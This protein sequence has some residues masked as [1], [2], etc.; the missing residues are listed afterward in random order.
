FAMIGKES[1]LGLVQTFRMVEKIRFRNNVEFNFGEN[2]MVYEGSQ[3]LLV[4]LLQFSVPYVK[5]LEFSD[6]VD[7]WYDVVFDILSKESKQKRLLIHGLPVVKDSARTALTNMVD[8]GVLIEFKDIKII[9]LFQ[10]PPC[11]FEC[12]IIEYDCDSEWVSFIR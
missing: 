5:C 3:A 11:N 2:Y 10:L 8:K 9:V 7:E 12:L 6:S 1:L 4:K